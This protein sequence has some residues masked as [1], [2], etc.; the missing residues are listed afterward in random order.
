MWS[1][2]VLHSITSDVPITQIVHKNE[3]DIW[4]P[5]CSG[6]RL[7]RD[8]REHRCHEKSDYQRC[9]QVSPEHQWFLLC[10]LVYD[11]ALV[12]FSATTDAS[13]E[14]RLPTIP[15]LFT[16]LQAASDGTPMLALHVGL[17]CLLQMKL[18][19]VDLTDRVE[20]VGRLPGPGRP[21]LLGLRPAEGAGEGM[22][23]SPTRASSHVRPRCARK[24]ASRSG[25]LASAL[26]DR[27]DGSGAAQARS[28]IAGTSECHPGRLTGLTQPPRGGA[29][30]CRTCSARGA[31]ASARQVPAVPAHRSWRGCCARGPRYSSAAAPT[32]RRHR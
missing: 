11:S 5:V 31:I 3:D 29:G 18:H 27:D 20:L 15:V 25:A 30:M 8:I 7:R 21:G 14:V 1:S 6:I 24:A 32:I 13:T 2:C 10:L 4:S 28:A 17:R 12:R 19:P 23:C 26:P 9:T 16:S 22:S